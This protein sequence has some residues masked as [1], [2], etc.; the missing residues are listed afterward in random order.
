M[1]KK[2]FLGLDGKISVHMDVRRRFQHTRKSMVVLRGRLYSRKQVTVAAFGAHSRSPVTPTISR[3]WSLPAFEPID[4][5]L[6]Y[7]E[8][9]SRSCGEPRW[10]CDSLRAGK[11]ASV[12]LWRVRD[13]CLHNQPSAGRKLLCLAVSPDGKFGCHRGEGHTFATV[14][15]RVGKDAP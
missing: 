7:S 3:R 1:F 15:Y 11:A 9:V 8:A 14:E 5:P 4:S 2:I 12:V 6:Q 13:V 10:F